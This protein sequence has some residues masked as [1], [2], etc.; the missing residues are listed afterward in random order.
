MTAQVTF[1]TTLRRHRIP[2]VAIAMLFAAGV[3]GCKTTTSLDDA[4]GSYAMAPAMQADAN[5]NGASANW[6]ER[7]RANPK[8]PVAAIN[9][10]KILRASGQRAQAVAVL[11]QASI[12]NPK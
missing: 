5:G 8:D 1:R 3:A 2:E 12:H 9:H 11:E 6:A 4:A 7:Y 10:A